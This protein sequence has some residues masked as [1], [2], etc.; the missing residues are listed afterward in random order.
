MY[1]VVRQASIYYA[2]VHAALPRHVHAAGAVGGLIWLCSG[3]VR[4]VA[5]GPQGW[6][7]RRP[8]VRPCGCVVGLEEFIH[9]FTVPHRGPDGPS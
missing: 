8:L 1:G 2:A 6:E 5:D 4:G 7:V 3:R 9:L